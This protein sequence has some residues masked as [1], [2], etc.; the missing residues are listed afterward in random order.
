PEKT[1]TSTE[2]VPNG[3]DKNGKTKYRTVI[4]TYTNPVYI[5]WSNKVSELEK[6]IATQREKLDLIVS[7]VEEY[8]QLIQ[9]YQQ[10]IKEFSSFVTPSGSNHYMVS[11]DDNI[12]NDHDEII[13]HFEDYT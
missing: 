10:V 4:H 1:L 3:T 2:D 13:N 5:E 6:Q 11:S 7:K 9:N 8:Y 12:V